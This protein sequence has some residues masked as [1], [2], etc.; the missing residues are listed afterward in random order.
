MVEVN[1]KITQTAFPCACK[2]TPKFTR[3]EKCS[4]YYAHCEHGS[5]MLMQCL[6]KPTGTC[7]CTPTLLREYTL[8]TGGT[9]KRYRC[10]HY[11]YSI[12]KTAPSKFKRKLGGGQYPRKEEEEEGADDKEPDTFVEEADSLLIV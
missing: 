4:Y 6:K 3:N 7:N 9:V 8:K 5:I 12:R 10:P 1:K 2:P 11:Y